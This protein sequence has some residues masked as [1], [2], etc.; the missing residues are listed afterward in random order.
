MIR[1]M[2]IKDIKGCGWVRINKNEAHIVSEED[3]D[4]VIVTL[5]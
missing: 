3:K 1:C 2:H 5:K 4:R